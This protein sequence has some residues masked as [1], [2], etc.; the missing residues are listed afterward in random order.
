MFWSLSQRIV[1]VDQKKILFIENRLDK[2]I[3]VCNMECMS[4]V[5]RVPLKTKDSGNDNVILKKMGWGK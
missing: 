4:Q 5:S 2:K 3:F 1:S